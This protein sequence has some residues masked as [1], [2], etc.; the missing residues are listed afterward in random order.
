VFSSALQDELQRFRSEVGRWWYETETIRQILDG[1]VDWNVKQVEDTRKDDELAIL[2]KVKE[3]VKSLN[4]A[5]K[6]DTK[7][8]RDHE[9]LKEDNIRL[10]KE[11]LKLR[12]EAQAKLSQDKLRHDTMRKSTAE[13]EAERL[14][15]ENANQKC[16]IEGLQTALQEA[17][18]SAA[19]KRG[20]SPAGPLSDAAEA[21][22]EALAR[23]AAHI[24]QSRAMAERK[25]LEGVRREKEAACARIAE[26]EE[27]VGV[28]ESELEQ[29]GAEKEL[30][31]RELD[32]VNRQ[33]KVA[34]REAKTGERQHQEQIQAMSRV[35]RDQMIAVTQQAEWR[36]ARLKEIHAREVALQQEEIRRVSDLPTQATESLRELGRR[37]SPD[38]D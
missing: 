21:Q 25:Q 8:F 5:L 22:T 9:Q 2:R 4:D 36:I 13:A 37:S 3:D 23:M 17:T 18:A 24:G 35:V 10:Q 15:R 29:T 7:L 32:D 33:L 20:Q 14:R 19:R 16:T 12:T 31:I 11:N 6:E 30:A 1:K 27:P 28:L 26:L 38:P 34:E